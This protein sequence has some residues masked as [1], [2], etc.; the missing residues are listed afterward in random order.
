MAET[1]SQILKRMQRP[2]VNT[3]I[4]LQNNYFAKTEWDKD[5][6]MYSIC[7]CR[8]FEDVDEYID[9]VNAIIEY[10]EILNYLESFDP[11]ESWKHSEDLQ[12][13]YPEYEQYAKQ[14]EAEGDF[15]QLEEAI[16][17]KKTAEEKYPDIYENALY[18]T[19]NGSKNF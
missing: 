15:K 2:P 9:E 4:E 3:A 6:K 14:L 13:T 5:P 19:F 1:N 10:A 17:F 12:N 18:Y 7:H 8:R 16:K 11:Y